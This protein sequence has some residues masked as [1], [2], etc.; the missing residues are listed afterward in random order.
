MET[1]SNVK[2]KYLIA[3]EETFG[4]IPASPTELDFGYVQTISISEDETTEEVSSINTEHTLAD[5]DD[6]LYNV[7][8]SITTKIS[9]P[10]LPNLLEALFGKLTEDSPEEGKYSVTTDP[11]TSSDLSYFMKFNT[12]TGKTMEVTG[13]GITGGELEV[14]RDGSVE[15]NLD[16]VARKLSP[17]TENLS[18]ETNVGSLFRGLDA[19]VTYGGDN[20]RL[21]DFSLSLDWN[22]DEAD[23]RGIEDTTDRRLIERI[24]RNQ[25]SLSGSFTSHMDDNIDTGYVSER[26]GVS[27]VLTL[28]RGTSNEHEFTINTAKTT[29]RSRD[30]ETGDGKK[31]LSCDFLGIDV[32][33]Q[34][35]IYSS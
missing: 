17:G 16:F 11:I 5:L 2:N 34:G 32:T 13:L 20:T 28:S 15:I 27:I 21:E 7:S 24:I 35:D 9:Q 3:K 12:E 26:S 6:D 22:Y 29:V 30:L 10:S 4:E 8:G 25:L 14:T 31:V 19:V 33:A 18:P 23:S 1:I